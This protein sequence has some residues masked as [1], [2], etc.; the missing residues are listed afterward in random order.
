[1]GTPELCCRRSGWHHLNQGYCKRHVLLT[2]LQIFHLENEESYFHVGSWY[3][4]SSGQLYAL[5]LV[6]NTATDL[7]VPL[8]H[9]HPGTL[10]FSA[11]QGGYDADVAHFMALCMRSVY[12][13]P[14]V[15]KALLFTLLFSSRILLG[16]S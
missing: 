6:N 7:S 10:P 13:K 2:Q 9:Y 3:R 4:T 11:E 15:I 14:E 16:M 5:S 8:S 1:M 12:E